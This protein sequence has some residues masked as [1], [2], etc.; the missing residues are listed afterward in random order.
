M[1][2]ADR[3]VMN[4][5][6]RQ[7]VT[8]VKGEGMYL[9]DDE[10]RKYLDFVAG[11]AVTALGHAHPAVTEALSKQAGTLL[12]TSNLYYTE[13]MGLLAEKLCFLLGFKD[14]R[15]FFANSG[16]EANECAIKLA[17]RWSVRRW[18]EGRYETI[19]A[20]GSFHG[21]TLETLAATGQPAKWEH[22][23]PLPPGFAHVPFGDLDSLSKAVGPKTCS[24]LLEPIQGEGG[25]V[26][27][28]DGYL[29]GVRHI[30]DERSLLFIA[31]EVQ[32]GL[33][34][35]G[36][37]FGFQH[38][39]GVPDVVTVA[40]ALGNGLPIGACIARGEAASAL[41]PGDHA[42]TMGGG[43]AITAAALAVL[44]TIESED[45]VNGAATKGASLIAGLKDLASSSSLVSEIRGT[46]LLMAM[47][48]TSAVAGKV[49]DLARA[50]GLLVNEVGP[51]AVRLCPPLIVTDDQCRE[52]VQILTE[53]VSE[54]EGGALES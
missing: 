5:Y 22:F 51:D 33:G 23:Q 49:V 37:W 15:V 48:L 32:T 8:F 38:D 36:K 53:V 7:P 47:S 2:L 31:D 14:G 19:A 30:C 27:S 3:W 16:A 20:F 52:A 26:P 25:I 54:L 12:H 28:P 9:F 13:P 46:G 29:A 24:V 21:R 17:R 4:T 6:R 1:N 10:G 43:P 41:E 42:T 11:I 45:L 40:K 44:E 18:G 39:E 50:K 35:T 34:R